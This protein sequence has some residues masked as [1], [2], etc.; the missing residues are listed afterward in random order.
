[1]LI[2][3]L[4]KRQVIRHIT[5]ITSLTTYQQSPSI[6]LYSIPTPSSKPSQQQHQH[7]QKKAN[8]GKIIDHLRNIIPDALHTVSDSQYLDDDIILRVA[9]TITN[10]PILKGRVSYLTTLKATQFIMTNF[11]LNPKVKLHITDIKVE[12]HGEFSSNLGS[13]IGKSGYGIYEWSTK[14]VFK[15]RTCLDECEHLVERSSTA[16]QG[17]HI[18]DK[19]DIKKLWGQDTSMQKE[20]FI[21]DG[22]VKKYDDD[23]FERVIYGIFVFELDPN[24]EKIIVH[25]VEN[26]EM[27]DKK[28]FIN[29]IDN[30]ARL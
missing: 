30:L 15:W 22:T 12:D 11:L 10:L 23:G 27:Y 19:F 17:S 8:I 21:D 24:C 25:N 9:P 26:I 3:T 18:F 13:S 7:Q 16:K 14:I 6:L 20:N 2:R 29:D 5:S 1:M 4:K 28:D